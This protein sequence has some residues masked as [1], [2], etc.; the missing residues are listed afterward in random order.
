MIETMSVLKILRIDCS[1]R[2]G[3]SVS[4]A[5][6]DHAV[7]T[8]QNN[9][10]MISLVQRDL[11]SGIGNISSAWRDASLLAD[12]ARSQEHRAVLAQSAALTN[13]VDDADV[14]LFSTPI[15]NF[16]IPAALK[17]WIDM[18]CRD[19]VDGARAHDINA[20][21]TSKQAVIILTS[22]Y[23]LADAADDFATPYLKFMLSFIGI[24]DITVID[25]T[26]LATG[27]HEVVSRA[28][29]AIS[30]ACDKLTQAWSKDTA[31]E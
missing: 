23:T 31:A 6:S 21:P 2:R 17:A 11:R 8:L 4:R 1:A 10:G 28:K 27:Q 16:T 15:Y 30:V 20:V 26:G 18:I 14:L 19:N 22:N 3:D 7:A 9:L 29:D 5:L 25:A 13:E 24:K 12:E